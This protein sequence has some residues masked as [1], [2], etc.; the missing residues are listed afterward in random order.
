MTIIS[1]VHL[2]L[3]KLALNSTNIS[4]QIYLSTSHTR[5]Q[6]AHA[7]FFLRQYYGIHI[8]FLLVIQLLRLVREVTIR[9]KF[10]NTFQNAP[11]FARIAVIPLNARTTL[12]L[13]QDNIHRL[14]QYILNLRDVDEPII[15][16]TLNNLINSRAD[17][18][19]LNIE[20]KQ[21]NHNT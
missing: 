3:L 19:L 1:F 21:F 12:N 14:A 18:L 5:T 11:P 4:H 20:Q 17:T 8:P 10:N 7:I 6:P 2:S 16:F 13:I 9:L 15:K